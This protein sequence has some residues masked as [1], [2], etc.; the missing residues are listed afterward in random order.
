[1]WLASGGRRQDGMTGS[2]RALGARM[3]VPE[4]VT[5]AYGYILKVEPAGFAHGL[6]R[7]CKK[8]G[9]L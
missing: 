2:H 1:M 4:V 3:L 5:L 6:G 7:V 8:D 9:K